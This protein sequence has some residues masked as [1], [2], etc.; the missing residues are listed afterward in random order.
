MGSGSPREEPVSFP[1]NVA[2]A[3]H[4]SGKNTLT[5]NPVLSVSARS[6]HPSHSFGHSRGVL[7]CWRCGSFTVR[8]VDKLGSV[9]PGGVR[10]YG[11]AVLRRLRKGKTPRSDMAWPR[12]GDDRSIPPD[13][14][15]VGRHEAPI[16][17]VLPPEE[18]ERLLATQGGVR[19]ANGGG[20]RG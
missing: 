7:W 4:S 16:I 5:I 14:V 19:G 18:K 13:V 20:D 1:T 9:C 6:L 12:G 8:K 11:Q 15:L 17:N 2:K 10:A 3:G